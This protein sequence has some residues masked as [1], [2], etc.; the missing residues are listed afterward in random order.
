M[1]SAMVRHLLCATVAA[2]GFLGS[3]LAAAQ[4]TLEV[5]VVELLKKAQEAARS[6]DYAGV[7]SYQDDGTMQSSRITH[8]VDGTGE[9]ERLEVL[10]GRPRE[11][12]RHN[13]TLHCLVPDKEL[14]LVEQARTDR[15][16]GLFL[17]DTGHIVN[18]YRFTLEPET[19]RVA[20]R[21]CQVVNVD[22]RSTDRYGYRFCVDSQTQLLVKAQTLEG[23]VLVDEIAFTFLQVGK[24]VSPDGLRS[25]WNFSG[26][27]QVRV[28]TQ[29]IDVAA[30]GWRVHNPAGFQFANQISRPMKSGQSVKHLV[31]SDGLAVISVF[32]E[33]Y[34]D[35]RAARNV[36][37]G[38]SRKGAI[39]VYS[40]RI[41]DSWVTALGA[42]PV[43]TLQAV[44]EQTQYVAPAPANTR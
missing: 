41:G 15:F 32:I 12:I 25:Q 34:D 42:V 2:F 22:P 26:W 7:F 17:G 38:P 21:E 9:R 11:F 31:L 24:Q 6:T 18:H 44:A 14:V 37:K 43:K 23:D 4:A 35:A 40:T 10:D 20:G 8:L 3:G 1:K 5:R 28:P 33:S 29:Q 39:N 36:I 16:P 19:S 27:K 13:E 30:L